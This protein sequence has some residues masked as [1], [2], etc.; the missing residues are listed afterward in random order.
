MLIKGMTLLGAMTDEQK[1]ESDKKFLDKIVKPFVA[2]VDQL[3]L[4]MI[5]MLGVFGAVYAITLGVQYSRAESSEKRE[6]AKKR[7]INGAIGIVVT[8]ILLIIMKILRET[9]PAV[10]DWVDQMAGRKVD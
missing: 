8:L 5:I 1:K 2:I 6:E 7:L 3:L 10:A 9:S 4:P